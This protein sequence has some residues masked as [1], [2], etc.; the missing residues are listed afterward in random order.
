MLD[1][2]LDS[3]VRTGE[4][5]YR[6]GLKEMLIERQDIGSN[7]RTRKLAVEATLLCCVHLVAVFFFFY[8]EF[9][10]KFAGCHDQP[11]PSLLID[12]PLKSPLSHVHTLAV[13]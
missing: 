7:P 4:T 13:S 8:Y 10:L 3:A 11:N 1:I 12:L 9:V 6:R 2:K 5:N